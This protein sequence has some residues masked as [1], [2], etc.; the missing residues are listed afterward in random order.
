MPNLFEEIRR[1]SGGGGLQ[2]QKQKQYSLQG[3][4]GGLLIWAN[5]KEEINL[6]CIESF[7]KRKYFH[8]LLKETRPKFAQIVCSNSHYYL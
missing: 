6:K 2:L 5:F 3:D 8:Q 1:K 4:E 7:V